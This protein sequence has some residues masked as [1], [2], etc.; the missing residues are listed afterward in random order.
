MIVYVPTPITSAE[1][2][3]ALPVGSI[4]PHPDRLPVEKIESGTWW[5]SSNFEG[6]TSEDM[7]GQQVLVPIE[8]EEETTEQIQVFRGVAHIGPRSVTL[9]PSRRLVTHWTPANPT[10]NAGEKVE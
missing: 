6:L 4:S 3:E 9:A 1:Q 8:A 7:V 5:G 10:E 2:A